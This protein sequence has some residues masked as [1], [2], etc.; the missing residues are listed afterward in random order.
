M[1]DSISL[2]DQLSIL[3]I[4]KEI[5]VDDVNS[6]LGRI[7]FDVLNKLTEQIISSTPSNAIE[8]INEIYNSG[9]EP[10]QILTNLNEYFKNLLVAKTCSK[11]LIP[12]LTGLNEPQIKDISVQAQTLETQQIVFLIER[13]SYYIKEVKQASNQHLW[14]EVGIIDL[15]NMAEN[16]TLLDLQNR[17]R[18]LESGSSAITA[19]QGANNVTRPAPI[20]P[21]PIENQSEDIQ[22][23]N[24]T[25]SVTKKEE[26]E[27]EFTPPPMSKKSDG[28]DIQSMW[29][30]LLANISSPST[31]GLL[32][33]ATPIQISSDGVILT[34]KSEKWVSSMNEDSK[35]QIIQNAVNSILGDNVSL[36]I[37]LAAAS[38]AKISPQSNEAPKLGKKVTKEQ[39]NNEEKTYE[40]PVNTTAETKIDSNKKSER[41]ETDQ[42]KMIIDLFDGKYVE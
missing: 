32:K 5:T 21:K 18:A 19:A 1:R 29:E 27:E 6:I 22:K 16:S 42:E 17:V 7:S 34:F 31:L 20:A 13:I 25:E 36:T 12:E 28:K 26:I 11:E 35:K 39:K 8:L 4:T 10:L 40:A 3:G 30:A 23:K 38:D 14:L 41:T 15:A 2:L 33:L 37:R 9:N 24:L